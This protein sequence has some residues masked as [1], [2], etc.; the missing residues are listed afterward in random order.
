VRV[1]RF[2]RFTVDVGAYELRLDG[3]PARLERR[4]MDLLILLIERRGQLV[5]RAEIVE[6]LWETAQVPHD[7][8]LRRLQ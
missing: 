6:H 5:T 7:S 2:D 1:F 3:R 8:M 4:P